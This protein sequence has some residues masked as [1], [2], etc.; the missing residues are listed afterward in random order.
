MKYMMITVITI[1]LCL[2][3]RNYERPQEKLSEQV[4]KVED[5]LK[6]PEDNPKAPDKKVED[7]PK[8]PDKKV[9]DKVV[10]LLADTG[11]I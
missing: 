8:A 1:T 3:L 2:V 4:K 11:F 6:V 10:I 5:N 9:K 7:N